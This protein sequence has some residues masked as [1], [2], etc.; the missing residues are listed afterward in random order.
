MSPTEKMSDEMD[1][2]LTY[3]PSLVDNEEDWDIPLAFSAE[4]HMEKIEGLE[5]VAQ[6][7]RLKDRVTIR[8]YQLIDLF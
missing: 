4:R 3:S 5:V 1:R 7:W 8:Y 6:T 2:A